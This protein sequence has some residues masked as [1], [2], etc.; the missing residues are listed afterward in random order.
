MFCLAVLVDA[1]AWIGISIARFG[2]DSRSVSHDMIRSLVD[3]M[4]RLPTARPTPS[5]NHHIGRKFM[6]SHMTDKIDAHAP[7]PLVV[8]IPIHPQRPKVPFEL[9]AEEGGRLPA[10]RVAGTL[11]AE[12]DEI[13]MGAGA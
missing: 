10:P 6:T 12:E 4:T 11:G 1:V 8:Q 2:I 3:V 7:W 5:V 13:L 9:A